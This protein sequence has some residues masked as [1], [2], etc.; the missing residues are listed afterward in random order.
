MNKL[1]SSNS[2]EIFNLLGSKLGHRLFQAK[3][4]LNSLYKFN[5]KSFCD[6]MNFPSGNGNMKR[7]QN[8]EDL[9]PGEY[10]STG[11]SMPASNQYQSNKRIRCS[12]LRD[13]MLLSL[14]LRK[15]YFYKIG[16]RNR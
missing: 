3:R 11:Y 16:K 5:K 4:G 6:D 13:G 9:L 2:N 10:R 7:T 12:F 1:K 14:Q 8:I 15:V